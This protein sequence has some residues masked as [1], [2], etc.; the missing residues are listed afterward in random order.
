[1]I[2]LTKYALALILLLGEAT[3][4]KAQTPGMFRGLYKNGEGTLALICQ[5]NSFIQCKMIK[6]D[7]REQL[8]TVVEETSNAV[9][10]SKACVRKTIDEYKV[11]LCSYFDDDKKIIVV[12]DDL[13]E[14]KNVIN[15]SFFK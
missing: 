13:V 1:M 7:T 2:N 5:R 4:V 11:S 3:V 8:L 6:I 15:E 10:E 14:N 9:Y 12:I